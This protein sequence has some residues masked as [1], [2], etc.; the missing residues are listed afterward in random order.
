MNLNEQLINYKE[1]RTIAVQEEKLLETIRKSKEAFYTSEQE[2]M[3]SYPAFL[4]VQF[5]VIQKRWWVFQFLLLFA[6]ELVLMYSNGNVYV[7]RSTGVIAS[8]FVIL[9]IPEF[10]KN[11]SCGCME[12]EA[13][14]YYSLR[15]IYAA[16]MLLFGMADSLLLTCFCG[17]AIFGLNLALPKLIIQFLFPLTMTA[18]ICFGTLCSSFHFSAATAVFLCVLWSSIW[19]LIILNDTIYEAITFPIGLFL[20]GLAFVFLSFALRRTLKCCNKYWEVSFN[21]IEV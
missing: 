20:F 17:A 7:Q 2:T 4:W 8:L 15:Q 19:L 6:L 10:W 16:R 9:M 13:V 18:C 21:G 5:K 1:K 14:S 11:R 12:V 3:L